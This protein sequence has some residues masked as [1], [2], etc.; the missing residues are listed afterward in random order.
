MKNILLAGIFLCLYSTIGLSQTSPF[1]KI[2][3]AELELTECPFEKDANAMVIFDKA[4]V[5]F[6]Q[7]FDIVMKRHKRIK[8]FNDKAKDVANIRLE[9]LGGNKLED[10][11][12]IQAQT[13]NLSNGKPEIIKLDKKSI[14]TENIDKYKKAV[15][16]TFPQV[17][18]GS[19]IEFKYEWK[20]QSLAN[21]PD[22]YFQSEIPVKYSEIETEIP[23]FFYYKTQ[24]K[25]KQE[26]VKNSTESNSKSMSAIGGS[27]SESFLVEKQIRAL[28]NIPSLPEEPFMT[29]TNDNLESVL[30]QLTMIK[31]RFGLV[32][33]F[34]DTWP[35]VGGVLADDEDFGG[36]LR[37]KLEGE[38][39]IILKAKTLKTNEEKIAY[40]FNEVKN[41]MK[42]NGVNRWYTNDGTSK[43]WDKKS[44]NSSEVNLIVYH[45]LTKAGIKAYPMVVS[46]KDHGKVYVAYPSLS[47][48]N[49]A[50]TYV[51][52]DS[53]KSFI[54][55]ATDKYQ[56]YF[57]IP[58]D[59]LNSF[60]LYIDKENKKY[61]LIEIVK[62]KPVRQATYVS[63]EIKPEGK[64]EG[65]VTMSNLDYKKSDIVRRYKTDG[66]DKYK[67]Y[68][69]GEDNSLKITSLKLEN[70]EVDTLPLTQQISFNKEMTGAEG[71]YLYLNPNIFTYLKSNPFLNEKRVTDIDFGYKNNYNISG[72]FKIPAGYKIESLPK[73]INMIMPD[74]SISFN[75]I[76]GEQDGAI[77]IRM[78]LDFKKTIFFKED[79]GDLYEF[80]KQLF[81]LLNEQ[82]VLKK[83]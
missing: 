39:A 49:K 67:E 83:I 4:D 75:R 13:I 42:W 23:E 14:Y 28:A 24:T 33:S 46:T 59:L 78:S 32:K 58:S 74:K 77:V 12:S 71:D 80:Y 79:Y 7:N 53:T 10:I 22:W 9:F 27:V 40:V 31:P 8:I 69:T 25:I 5:Y 45:L 81:N 15:I 16:F 56:P 63:A 20:T 44:G 6:D 34:A 29:S 26:Y 62:N 51:P 19:I 52:I 57:Q 21:F 30:F 73:S 37:R 36:Q 35:K 50:V 54:L 65:T 38:E 68:L 66:E 82:V 18:D 55:D 43:A 72:I 17:K 3:I 60:G 11:Y 2:E 70:A 48:F 76:T 61:D 1:G 47:H 41:T 64:I